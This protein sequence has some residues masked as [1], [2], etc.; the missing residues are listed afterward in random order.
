MKDYEKKELKKFEELRKTIEKHPLTQQI[1]A[2]RAAET[3]EKRQAAAGTIEA[4]KRKRDQ[5]IPKLRADLAGKEEEFKKAK[6]T[7]E[8]AGIEFQTARVALFGESQSFDNSISRQEEILIE[9]A[10]P[11]IDEAI[12]FFR[13]RHEA[14]LR[15]NPEITTHKGERNIFQ[16]TRNLIIISNAPAIKN[17]LRYSLACIKELMIMKLTPI[18]DTGQIEVL[19]RGIPDINETIES[20]GERSFPK[21]PPSWDLLMRPLEEKL[22]RLFKKV[23]IART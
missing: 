16:I 8:V 2:E 18:P 1:L 19:K 13:D 15:K 12:Q 21:T 22:D 6:V 23:G 17:A 3:L 4:L 5:V 14:L 10:D 11:L 9:T 20:M 7:F